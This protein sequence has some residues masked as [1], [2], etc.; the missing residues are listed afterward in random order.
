MRSELLRWFWMRELE[1]QVKV[2]TPAPQL[3]TVRME[4]FLQ[5]NPRH[6]GPFWFNGMS[7][8]SERLRQAIAALA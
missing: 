6:P 3:K 5:E 1:I 4:P 2:R 8:R 7:P